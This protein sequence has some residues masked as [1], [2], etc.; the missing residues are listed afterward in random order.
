VPRTIEPG[1]RYKKKYVLP[2]GFI[3]GPNP[4]KIYDSFLF[5]AIHHVSALQNEGLVIWN[6]ELDANFTS[7]PFFFLPVGMAPLSGLVGH[8]G[9][10]GCRI[11]CLMPNGDARAYPDIPVGGRSTN[12]AWRPTRKAFDKSSSSLRREGKGIHAV[13]VVVDKVRYKEEKLVRKVKS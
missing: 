2:S 13:V 8:H 10:N 6:A 9:K 11:Y 7:C 1:V 3:P 4:P 12:D 5:P